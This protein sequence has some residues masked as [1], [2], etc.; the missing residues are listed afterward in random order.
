MT[1][2]RRKHWRWDRLGLGLALAALSGAVFGYAWTASRAG[3]R[4]VG[5][6]TLLC[7]VLF[8]LSGVYARSRPPGTRVL[9]LGD[10]LIE[11]GWITENQLADALARH[12]HMGGRFGQVLVEMKLITPSQLAR[13]LQDQQLRKDE[14]EAAEGE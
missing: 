7:G 6:L 4:W 9:P 1:R 2:L 11:K 5:A 12:H 14:Q 10:L 13:A 3:W 8:I